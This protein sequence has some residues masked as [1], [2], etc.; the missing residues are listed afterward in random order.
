MAAAALFVVRD[1][2]VTGVRDTLLAWSRRPGLAD[3]ALAAVYGVAEPAPVADRAEDGAALARCRSTPASARS[4]SRAR[5]ER[6]VVVTGPPGNGKSHALVAAALDEVDRGGSVLVAAQSTAAV[7]GAGHAAAPV[8]RPD[9]GALRRRRAPRR[10]RRPPRAGWPGTAGPTPAGD[11]PVAAAATTGGPAC[12]R[13]SP[14]RSSW[15]SGP[16]PC[17]TW[18]PL[19]PALRTDAPGAFEPGVRPPD[20]APP[21]RPGHRRPRRVGAGVVGPVVGPVGPL[22]AAPAGRRRARYHGRPARAPRSTPPP[23]SNAAARLAASGGTDLAE[24]W[25]SLVDAE[26]ALA[27]RGRRGDAARGPTDGG[28]RPARRSATALAAALRAG[29]NRRREMLAG[30]DGRMLVRALPLW[31][32]TVTDVEDLL[33]PVP[34]LF[35]LVIIDEAVH[36][37]QIRAAPVLARA[38]RALR[39]R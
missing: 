4:S 11:G 32:G 36:V 31:V 30:L 35:D 23:R 8:P 37:D 5:R 16:P 29:R 26:A 22:A 13:P 25:R 18:E 24:V 28:V 33:P 20:R 34:G 19:L 7:A 27:A 10:A 17:P 15:R 2:R 14:P 21:G 6:V 1:V 12:G 3:T 39:R 38:R 9:A